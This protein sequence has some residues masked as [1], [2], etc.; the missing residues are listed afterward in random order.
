M[1]KR[2]EDMEIPDRRTSNVLLAI[3]LFAAAGVIL[4]TR[5]E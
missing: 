2:G 5:L 1:M 4:L 3:L